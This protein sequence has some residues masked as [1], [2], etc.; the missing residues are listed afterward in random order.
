MR[1]KGL[2][3][4]PLGSDRKGGYFQILIFKERKESDA[5]E[6]PLAKNNQNIV[7]RLGKKARAY[8]LRNT[9]EKGGRKGRGKTGKLK[10]RNIKGRTKGMRESGAGK[11]TPG[12]G[13]KGKVRLG[14]RSP[15]EVRM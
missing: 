15:R 8:Q 13:E 9:Q 1:R 14:K 3:G 6:V 7:Q 4:L 2:E 10:E 5:V 11:K 12:W